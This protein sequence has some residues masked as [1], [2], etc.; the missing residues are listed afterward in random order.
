MNGHQHPRRR[1]PLVGAAN[2]DWGIVRARA[3]GKPGCSGWSPIG[4]AAVRAGL[5]CSGFGPFL[6]RSG[7]RCDRAGWGTLASVDLRV[8][9]Q[10]GLWPPLAIVAKTP[11]A[12]L[13]LP[14]RIIVNVEG[15]VLIAHGQSESGAN[16]RLS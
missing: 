13:F 1:R 14:R 11:R 6:R 15:G 2:A 3:F 4:I 8:E 9:N 5:V 10:R 16:R 7:R 12:R